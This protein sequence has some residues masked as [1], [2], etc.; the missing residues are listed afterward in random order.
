MLPIKYVLKLIEMITIIDKYEIYEEE[1]DWNVILF[2]NKTEDI[3][4]F[5]D[6]LKERLGMSGNDL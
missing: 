2:V 3:N 5:T 6:F 1:Y 4:N